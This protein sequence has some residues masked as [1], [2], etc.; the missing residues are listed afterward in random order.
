MAQRSG[1]IKQAWLSKAARK[2]TWALMLAT[3][4]LFVALG[5]YLRYQ[6]QQTRQETISHTARTLASTT[7]SGGVGADDILLKVNDLLNVEAVL[8]VKLIEGKDIPLSVG[9][10]L[11]DFPPPTAASHQVTQWDDEFNILDIAIRLDKELPFNWIV[12]RLNAAQLMAHPMWGTIINWVAA[13]FAALLMGL[14]SLWLWGSYYIRRLSAIQT[15]LQENS[16]KL[17][18]TPITQDLTKGTDD[19]ALLAKQIEAMRIEVTDEKAKSDFQARFLHETPYALMRCS[20][21]RKVLYANAAARAEK[22]LFGDESKE[23]VAP[24]LS[25][26]VRKA[27]YETR[28]VFGDIRCNDQIITFRAIPVLDA[29]YVN[30]YGEVKRH[31]DADI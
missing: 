12:L 6:E 19:I 4:C 27:F 30:L 8:G 7:L 16:G 17:A 24:A 13:P 15:Y 3:F 28:E 18:N 26:L 11:T 25:E 9:D 20:V 21:N 2:A 29:G 31:I 22:A 23:F 10:T 1:V 5:N 14:V